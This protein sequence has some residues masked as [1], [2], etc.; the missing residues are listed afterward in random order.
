MLWTGVVFFLFLFF[1]VESVP[2]AKIDNYQMIGMLHDTLVNIT[3]AQCHCQMI[4]LDGLI[5]ASNY[6]PSNQTC[7]L[8]ASNMSSMIIETNSNS[9][10]RFVNRTA[11]VITAVQT[12]GKFALPEEAV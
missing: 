7:Q 3:E 1:A 11:V 6:F 8:F 12:S 10:L 9:L 2:V 4:K 5:S